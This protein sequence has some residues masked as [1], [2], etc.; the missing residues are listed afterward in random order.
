MTR[1]AR[2]LDYLTLWGTG[3]GPATAGQVTVRLGG[4]SYPVSYVGRSAEYLGLDQI[5][6]QVPDDPALTQGC[7]VPLR[8][9]I[10]DARSNTVVV[11]LSRD[12]SPCEHP[13]RLPPARLAE[14]E[15][16]GTVPVGRFDLYSNIGPPI[17]SDVRS[18]DFLPE[19]VRTESADA[20]FYYVNA[21]SLAAISPP[22]AS[23]PVFGCEPG[24]LTNLIFGIISG[25][26]LS[27]GDRISLTGP[28]GKLVDLVQSRF[29]VFPIGSYRAPFMTSEPVATPD[30]VPPA[31]FSSGIWRIGAPGSQRVPPFESTM[32]IPVPIHATNSS[33]L[34]TIDP[35]RDVIINWDR[36]SY[37]DSDVLSVQ[38]IAIHVEDQF[39]QDFAAVD[40]R[41][42]AGAGQLT[43]PAGL[44][45]PLR[46]LTAEG[47]VRWI[48]LSVT[49]GSGAARVDTITL[50][51]DTAMPLIYNYSSAELLFMRFP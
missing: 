20:L 35:S 45:A 26:S 33:Q 10:G 47:T 44:L 17:G 31:F 14:L 50:A 41:I 9:Q 1:P 8:L 21:D 15:A 49:P 40:C 5:N 23:Q 32:Y 43:I 48:S 42:P 24:S 28:G 39:T 16:G 51:D 22:T 36:L 38:I 7:Y 2:P 27:V 18:P 37:G 46:Q 4:R 3:F 6:I 34:T 13:L 25:S 30:A 29:S 12:G 19:Y 11:S